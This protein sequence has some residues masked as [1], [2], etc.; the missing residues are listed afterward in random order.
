[1]VLFVRYAILSSVCRNMLVM[2]VVSLPMQV[3]VAH[4]CLGVREGC[5]CFGVRWEGFCGL[6][7]KELLY[8]MLRMTSTSC[9]FSSLCRSQ[10]LSLLYRNFIAAYLC[11][12]GWLEV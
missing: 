7:G 9:W 4:L 5:C 10:E 11:C 6:I 8:M 3:N 1:M 2:C 12:L